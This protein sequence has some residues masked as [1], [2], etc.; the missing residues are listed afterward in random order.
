MNEPPKRYKKTSARICFVLG[1][2]YLFF[3]GS[4]I[5]AHNEIESEGW[6]ICMLLAAVF[7]TASILLTIR[8][9]RSERAWAE[10]ER[11]RA[12]ADLLLREKL[13][14]EKDPRS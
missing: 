13:L 14:D 4:K 6:L 2:I 11:R 1:F 10:I 9:R 8:N 3:T 5:A 7:L 12:E